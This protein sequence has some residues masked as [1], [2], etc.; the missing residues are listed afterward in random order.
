MKIAARRIIVKNTPPF[1]VA[2]W[3]NKRGTSLSDHILSSKTEKSS[4]F[5]GDFLWRK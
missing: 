3:G 1:K 5:T 4:V 2:V